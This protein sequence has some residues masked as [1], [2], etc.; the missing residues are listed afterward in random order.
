MYLS[1]HV[2]NFT[3]FSQIALPRDCTDPHSHQQG[4]WVQLITSLPTIGINRFLT[5]CQIIWCGMLAHCADLYFHCSWC[6]W[7]SSHVLCGPSPMSA[8]P[9]T[10]T[11][12]C[13]FLSL[14]RTLIYAGFPKPVIFLSSESFMLCFVMENILKPVQ[15]YQWFLY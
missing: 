6:A 5:A 4:L 13:C 11:L 10:F 2:L 14:L 8:H 12:H 7:C 9:S 3:I 15:L 1:M